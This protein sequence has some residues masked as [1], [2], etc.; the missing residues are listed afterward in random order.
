MSGSTPGLKWLALLPLG[1]LGSGVMLVE[2]GDVAV[3]FRFG[4]VSR[5]QGAGIGWRVPWPVEHHE[6]VSVSEVR[7]VEPGLTRMLTG[8]TNLIDLDLVVQVTVSDPVAWLTATTHPEKEAAAIVTAMATDV[9][10]TMDVDRLLT[11]GRAELQQRVLADAQAALTSLGSGARLDAIDIREL[12]PPPAVVDAFNDVSSARGDRE[13]LALGAEAYTSKLL[14]EARGQAA[15]ALSRAQAKAAERVTGARADVS[16]FEATAQS[17]QP[18]AEAARL[19]AAALASAG[20]RAKVRVVPPGT[21]LT[22]PDR[23]PPQE[24]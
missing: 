23:P 15:T 20:Q 12:T 19:R 8:D 9:V 21:V 5:S 16:R 7:R 11:T 14:P 3:V 2:T 4:E 10:S 6:V 13:T 1:W 17:S 24:P 18:R 22:L